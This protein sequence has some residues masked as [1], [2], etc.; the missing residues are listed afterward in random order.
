MR[1]GSMSNPKIQLTVMITPQLNREVRAL[2]ADYSAPISTVVTALLEHGIE[3]RDQRK[4]KA[5]LEAAAQQAYEVRSEI[6][7]Q[8]MAS[9][10]GKERKL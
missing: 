2:A 10:W 3:N 9:R 5:A 6:G 4:V 8:S 7:R 1:R